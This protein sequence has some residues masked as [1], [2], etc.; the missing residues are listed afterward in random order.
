MRIDDVSTWPREV[1]DFIAQ[2]RELFDEW[3]GSTAEARERKRQPGQSR[4]ERRFPAVLHDNAIGALEEML[5]G[6]TL[7]AA[8]HCTRLTG[9]EMDAICA[10]GMWPQSGAT[11][12]ARIDDLRYAGVMDEEV[13]GVLSTNNSADDSNRAG[14]IW[15]CFFPPYKAGESGIAPLLRLWGGEALYRHHE[16]SPRVRAVLETSGTPSIIVA[17]VRVAQLN[18]HSFL[19]AKVIRRYLQQ[20]GD[21]IQESVDHEGYTRKPVPPAAIRRIVCYPDPE[22]LELTRCESWRNPL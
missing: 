2:N 3:Y 12:R 21:T 7:E 4:D 11:L 18:E 1:V 5:D 20:Q 16:S 14:M 13:A 10:E 15:F 19:A 17:D 9:R 8:F 22:F 6:Q